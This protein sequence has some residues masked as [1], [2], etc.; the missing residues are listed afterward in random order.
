MN[1]PH[2]PH[3]PPASRTGMHPMLIAAAL[4]VILF[5]LAGTAAILGWIPNSIGGASSSD[6][7]ASDRAALASRL[8]TDARAP[9]SAP[10]ANTLALNAD[11]ER[12]AMLERDRTA[13][14]RERELADLERER[15]RDR[16]MALERE[17]EA[18][19]RERVA[20]QRERDERPVVREK[21]RV[22]QAAPAKQWCGNCGN[23][24]SVRQISQRAQGSGLGA[25]GGAVLGGLLGSQIGD[26]SGKKIATVAGAVGGAVV[27]NQVEGNMKATRSYEVR[28]RLDSG[29]ER[30][31]NLQNLNGFSQGDRV[32]VVDGALRHAG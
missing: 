24:V 18:E 14:E 9:L 21:T 19:R 25:A 31:F 11:G 30:T 4:A 6:L 5:C 29:K 28:V 12:L 2:S 3:T 10:P 27:G 32:K 17:H 23:V 13:A 16:A 20:E 1:T 22:A 8:D 7:S 15:E 26:G